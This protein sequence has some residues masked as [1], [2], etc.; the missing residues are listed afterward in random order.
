MRAGCAVHLSSCSIYHLQV[1]SHFRP[2]ALSYPS[3]SLHSPIGGICLQCITT[4]RRI[5]KHARREI[6]RE[7]AQGQHPTAQTP[8][9]NTS[10]LAGRSRQHL[11][12]PYWSAYHA[13]AACDTEYRP[14]SSRPSSRLWQDWTL[15]ARL[16][17][18]IGENSLLSNTCTGTEAKCKEETLPVSVSCRVQPSLGHKLVRVGED[19]GVQP[20]HAV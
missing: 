16:I 5:L 15:S 11:Q 18:G 9:C 10:Q 12:D 7:D 4:E 20:M 13:P 2:Q 1:D 19:A 17:R 3:K 6:L 8:T 14:R